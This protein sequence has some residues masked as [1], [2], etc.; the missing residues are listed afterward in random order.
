MSKSK[1]AFVLLMII[2]AMSTLLIG[3]IKYQST[4][5]KTEIMRSL[6]DDGQYTLF[7]YMIGEPDWPFGATHCRFDLMNAD[8]RII[9]Y[10]FDIHDDGANAHESNFNITWG[11]DNVTVLVS[12]SEQKDIFYKLSFDGSVEQWQEEE[13]QTKESENT[14]EGTCEYADDEYPMMIMVQDI[15]YYDCAEIGT[16]PRCG[17]L[18][19][20]ID[21]VAEE[22]PV[23]NNQSNFGVDYG[24]QF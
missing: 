1:E 20:T 11:K 10:S 5:E 2:L 19:G 17:I 16:E 8:K 24:Y 15:L 9:K 21:K 14:E 3:G 4:Y 12:G 7:V 18:D 23:E 13:Q 22:V 6:S